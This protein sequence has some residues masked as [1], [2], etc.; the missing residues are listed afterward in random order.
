MW[1][2]FNTATT[3]LYRLDLQDWLIVLVAAMALGFY[4]LQG[5]HTRSNP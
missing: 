3:W 1:H 2:M 5:H 4:C